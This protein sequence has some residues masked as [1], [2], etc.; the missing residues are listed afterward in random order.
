RGKRCE[1]AYT[2]HTARVLAEV[3]G[4]AEAEMARITTENFHRLYAKAA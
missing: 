1:P 2:V 3:K 4:V